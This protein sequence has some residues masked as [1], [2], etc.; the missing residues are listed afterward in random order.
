M[1]L[2]Y[3]TLLFLLTSACGKSKQEPAKPIDPVKAGPVIKVMTYNIHIGNPPSEVASAR[4]L[5]AIAN[6][7]NLQKPDLVALQEV[8]VNTTRSGKDVD[9]AKELARLTGMYYFYTKA[10]DY[11]GGQFGD[12]VLSRLPIIESK[13]YELSV[14]PE[15]G[16]ET[17]SVAMIVVEKEG[18]RFNFASTHLDH[19]TSDINRD[20]QARELVNHIK[21]LDKP[22]IIAGDL[23]SLPTS[24]TIKTLQEQLTYACSSNCPLTFPSVNANRTID[25]ILIN[26]PEKFIVKDYRIVNEGYASDHLPVVATIELKQ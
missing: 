7:I 14:N 16:G 5:Q 6:V 9:Q 10:I 12:A 15:L 22:L 21:V 19:L 3:F 26:K 1:R 13:R 18:I 25:Y 4:N 11:Q 8:D 2:Y 23:N 24:N 17:R 20:H